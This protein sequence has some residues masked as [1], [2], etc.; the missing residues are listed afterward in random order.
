M[1][2][3]RFSPGHPLACEIPRRARAKRQRT[4]RTPGRWRANGSAGG[5]DSVLGCGSPLP[6]FPW[7]SLG[8]RNPPPRSCKAPGDWRTPGRW[9]AD[10]KRTVG[11]IASWGAAVLCR[12]SPA[13]PACGIPTPRPSKA[14]GDWRTPGRWRANG[15][16]GGRDSVLECGS[17]LPLFPWPSLGVRNPPAALVQSARG[18][19]HSRTLARERKHR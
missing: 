18:L 11:A 8:V 14:P 4:G 16:A 13:I 3:Y 1:A 15:S 9:R 7:P 2:R 6:L 17:P 5:R 19:A 10:R 12:F